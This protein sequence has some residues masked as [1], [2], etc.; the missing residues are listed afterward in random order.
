M[1]KFLPLVLVILIIVA[2]SVAYFV[3]NYEPK[4]NHPTIKVGNSLPIN[5]NEQQKISKH[6]FYILLVDRKDAFLKKY[7]W[8]LEEVINEKLGG[9]IE[10][11]DSSATIFTEIFGLNN[12]K[13]K[14]IFS[15]VIV[16]DKNAKIIGVY[17][18]KKLH[19]LVD[20]LQLH[21]DLIDLTLAG[22]AL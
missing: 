12:E 16:T 1:R 15:V 6:K 20:V 7:S 14:K 19:E 4:L 5:A 11:A 3:K 8:A 21:P 18:N 9:L 10:R 2:T 13:N 17:P 22:T